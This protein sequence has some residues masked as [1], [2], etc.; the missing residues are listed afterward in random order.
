M[1]PTPEQT[2]VKLYMNEPRI[3]SR[4][5]RKTAERKQ[6]LNHL[7]MTDEQFE[8]WFIMFERNVK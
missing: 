6:W 2:L 3:F 1:T 7:Q 5:A 8:G 4:Q